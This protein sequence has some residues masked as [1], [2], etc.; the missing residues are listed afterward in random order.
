M[1]IAVLYICTGLYSEFWKGFYE[2]SQKYFF[3]NEEVEYF[4]FT[5]SSSIK[6]TSDITKIH[7][8]CKGF[9]MDSLFRF[10]MF[11]EIKDQLS[12]FDYIFFFNSN[13]QFVD[14]VAHEILPSE[15][16]NNLTAGVS[17]GYYQTNSAFFPY[18]RN[19]KSFAYIPYI[20]DYNYTYYMGGLNGGKSTEFLDLIE[21]CANWI[22]KD[23]A[24]HIIAI[25]HDES[26]LNKYLLNKKVK[27]LTPDYGMPE[28]W[29][30][31]MKPKIIIRDK[32]KI[33]SVF[34]KGP[35]TILNRVFLKAKRIYKAITWKI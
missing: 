6:S 4:V 23:Y 17:P 29:A 11:L 22:E 25:Y 10:A 31:N 1:K 15:N 2:S 12:K 18:E 27:V 5:D 28:G 26:H 14:Y 8:E 33:N 3:I 7:K 16:E 9:P 13:M 32:I 19:K 20:K 24:K 30:F 35:V 34:K 21:T